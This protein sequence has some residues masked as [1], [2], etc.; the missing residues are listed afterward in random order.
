MNDEA[1]RYVMHLLAE[2]K[3]TQVEVQSSMAAVENLVN[4]AVNVSL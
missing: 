3:Q 2:H 4:K 1:G